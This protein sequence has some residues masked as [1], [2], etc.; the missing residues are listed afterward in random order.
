VISSPP[1]YGDVQQE[2]I[3]EIH[4]TAIWPDVVTVDGNI[5]NPYQSDFIGRDDSYIIL[6]PDGDFNSFLDEFLG[7][8]LERGELARIWNSEARFVEAGATEFSMSQQKDIINNLSN[9]RIYNCIIVSQQNYVLDKENSRP[10]NVSD[11]DT[12]MKL[13]V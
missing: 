9:F 7:L 12:G 3:A 5:R 1:T 4:R 11:L 2:L 8:V 6:I 10:I 13:G